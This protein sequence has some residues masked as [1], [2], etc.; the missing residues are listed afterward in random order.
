MPLARIQGLFQVTADVTDL[1]SSHIALQQAGRGMYR[2]T[3]LAA[4]A[5][6]G[7]FTINDGTSDIVS[8]EPIP[9]KAAAVTYPQLEKS[10]DVAWTWYSHRTDRPL[11]N[12]VDGTN[13]EI[14]AF[15]EKLK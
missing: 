14:V 9:V 2:L 1:C 15:V 4:A 10:E 3:I 7:T 12:I 13:G 11:I 8:L 5:A 6:D